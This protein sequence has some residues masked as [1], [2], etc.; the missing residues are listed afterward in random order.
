MAG[1]SMR[2]GRADR[3]D[4]DQ[5]GVTKCNPERFQADEGLSQW[6]ALAMTSATPNGLRSTHGWAMM[7]VPWV[8]GLTTRSIASRL[9]FPI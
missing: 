1:K 9:R 3:P 8:A 2:L 6:A 7:D 5:D 4:L